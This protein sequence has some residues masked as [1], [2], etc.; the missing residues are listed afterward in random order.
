[1]SEKNSP[2]WVAD[3]KTALDAWH[4]AN[5]NRSIV[6]IAV[7]EDENNSGNLVVNA[8]IIGDSRILAA[9]ATAAMND[10]SEDN[11]PGRVLRVAA[12][13]HLMSHAKEIGTI[14]INLSGKDEEEPETENTESHE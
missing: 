3:L 5:D 13:K 10:G 7:G 6:M 8:S 12:M 1:M 9:A 4:K 11:A 14:E 2:E